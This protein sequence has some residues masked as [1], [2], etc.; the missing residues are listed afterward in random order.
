MKLFDGIVESTNHVVIEQ[1]ELHLSS[2]NSVSDLLED[3]LFTSRIYLTGLQLFLFI[4]HIE[5]PQIYY[6]RFHLDV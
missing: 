3:E 6:D 2:F 5:F 4:K 1:I